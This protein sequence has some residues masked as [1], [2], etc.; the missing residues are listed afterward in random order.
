MMPFLPFVPFSRAGRAA[1]GA[2]TDEAWAGLSSARPIPPIP[3]TPVI[4]ARPD[5][6]QSDVHV[7][8]LRAPVDG[9]A[10]SGDWALPPLAVQWR[11]QHGAPRGAGKSTPLPAKDIE[12]VRANGERT[13]WVIEAGKV[14]NEKPIQIVREIWNA[15]DLMVTLSSRDFDPRSGEINYRLRNLKRGEPD[16]A[17]MRVPADF[18]KPTRPGAP[19]ASGPNG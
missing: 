16:A 2:S 4:I 9:D 8:V 18:A 10:S 17:L 15:P 19:K 6:G 13:T 5:A 1:S 14:G 11:A 7:R 12:G 3:P